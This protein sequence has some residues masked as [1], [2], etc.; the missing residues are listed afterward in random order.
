LALQDEK[1][2][3][4]T[5]IGGR[6]FAWGDRTYVMGVVNATPDSFSGDG[7]LPGIGDVQGAIDQ[8]LR[9][10]DE[11][12]DIIDV[13][14]ES[15]RPASVY[16]GAAPVDVDSE[17]ARVVPVIE[18][19]VGR[20]DVPISTDTRKAA[21]AAAAIEAGAVLVNDVSMLGDPDM[22]GVIAS[23]EVP[24]VVSHIRLGGNPG[25]GFSEVIDDLRGA[26]TRLTD[27]GV[28]RWQIIVDPG[29]GFAKNPE[30]SLDLLRQLGWI[31]ASIF[32]P[33]LVGTS[34]KSF[35]ETV[36]GEPVEDRRFGTAATVALAIKA[37]ADIV[38][39]HDVKEMVRVAKMT[40]AIVRDQ[41]VRDAQNAG[42]NLV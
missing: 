17:I 13:G 8:A 37:G 33:L 5:R 38:R 25:D 40:D 24:V 36:T 16:P 41:D 18:G 30:Q 32:H 3:V 28:L 1:P 20:L 35:I 23:K 11:G 2:K 39:V 42:V 9:M 4:S 31:S 15:T 26:I 19:L 22:V 27:A 14:G 21:V 34:R 12:A 10:E 6:K 7:V 29:I